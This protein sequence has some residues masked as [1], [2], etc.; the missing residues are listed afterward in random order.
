MVKK[1]ITDTSFY[2]GLRQFTCMAVSDVMNHDNVN[3]IIIY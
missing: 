2:L 1:E 3:N